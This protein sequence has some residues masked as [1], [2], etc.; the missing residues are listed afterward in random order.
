MITTTNGIMIPIIFKGGLPCNEHYYPTDAQMIDITREEITT[1]PGEWNPSLIDDSAN[2]AE[3]QLSEFP[4]KPIDATYDFYIM[5]GNSIVQK[6]N[7][8]DTSIVSDVSSASSGRRRRT[9]RV[10]TRNKK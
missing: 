10:Q 7:S 6:S 5:D 2:A 9:Y 1:S 4:S 8:D 3:Q